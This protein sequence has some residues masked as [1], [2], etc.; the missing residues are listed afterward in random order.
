[1]KYM[2]KTI[3]DQKN[4]QWEVVG[5]TPCP[6]SLKPSENSGVSIQIFDSFAA[7]ALAADDEKKVA[8]NRVYDFDVFRQVWP[9]LRALNLPYSWHCSVR[10]FTRAVIVAEAMKAA[11]IEAAKRLPDGCGLRPQWWRRDREELAARA[12]ARRKLSAGAQESGDDENGN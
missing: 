8:K 7:A 1:M 6:D 5:P 12:A 2:V 3:Q 10:A 11:S 4:N 9:F